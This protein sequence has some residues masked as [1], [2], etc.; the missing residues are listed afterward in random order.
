MYVSYRSLI[1]LA[2]ELIVITTISCYTGLLIFAN[3]HDCDPITSQV[4][5]HRLIYIRYLKYKITLKFTVLQTVKKGNY[6][7]LTSCLLQITSRIGMY[8][9]SA[10]NECIMKR[11]TCPSTCSIPKNS[12]RNFGSREYELVVCNA[13][14]GHRSPTNFQ[15]K[16]S[17]TYSASKSNSSKKSQWISTK[18]YDVKT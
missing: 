17:P 5:Q 4:I 14:L 6:S 2:I 15:R 7:R 16:A 10:L 1:L 3:Y 11:P 12:R 13:V 9:L 18:L 8:A